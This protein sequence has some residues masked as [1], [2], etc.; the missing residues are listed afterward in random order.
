MSR[1]PALYASE[2]GQSR[3]AR[4]EGPSSTP[5]LSQSGTPRIPLQAACTSAVD[6]T[7][8]SSYIRDFDGSP[9]L[10]SRSE[11]SPD[12]GRQYGANDSTMGFAKII[13]GEDDDS[14]SPASGTIP[15]DPGRAT[16]DPQTPHHISTPLPCQGFLPIAVDAYFDRVNWY[17]MLFHQ[18]SFVNRAQEILSRSTWPQEDL[19]EVLLIIMVA[20]LGLRCVEHD[21]TWNGH[22]LLHAY[23]ATAASLSSELMMLI[24]SH[25]YEVLMEARIEAY[26]ICMLMANYHVYF[27]SS[28]FAWNV[29]GV[30]ARTAYALAL[31]CDKAKSTGGDI[32]REV[33]NRCWNHLVVSDQFSSM[34][35]G[36][37]ATLDPAFAQFKKLTDLDDTELPA[38]TARLGILQGS[39]PKV[40]FLTYHALKFEIYHIIRHTLESFKVLQLR[41]PVTVQDLKTLI[42]VVNSTEVMLEQ[43]HE[44]LPTVFKPSQW[45]ADDPWN[46]LELDR[47][48]WDE[49]NIRRKLGLQGFILQLLYDAARV[50]A[51]RP[52]LKLRISIPP[53][54]S[55]E[56][57]AI[58][59][60]PDSLGAS[61]QAALR[62]SRVPVAE[63]DG[64]LAQSFVLMHLFTAGSVLCIA[65]TCQPYSKTAG[66]AKAGVLRIISACR[67]IKDESKIAR[68]ID[69]M[70]TRLYKKT[71][72]REMDNA[73]RLPPD[74]VP[75]KHHI[76]IDHIPPVGTKHARDTA[77]TTTHSQARPHSEQLNPLVPKAMAQAAMETSGNIVPDH[78]SGSLNVQTEYHAH[79]PDGGQLPP[80]GEPV[81]SYLHF[82][83][84]RNND[85]IE[86][87]VDEDFDGTFGAFEE[88]KCVSRI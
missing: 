45:P 78:R 74:T 12:E 19:C 29:S 54:E 31:H 48:D 7:Q 38:D 28:N 4:L 42:Q 66:E 51:R 77:T 56:N 86:A 41:S 65:P 8:S 84:L 10:V 13:L 60:V 46:V 21:K 6:Q 22:Q 83:S 11:A 88:S 85:R 36:R 87:H 18:P 61:V 62:M 49:R 17:I 47:C 44:N 3:G 32:A 69:Q 33:S 16:V 72:E 55:I 71:M 37:P 34:I 64:H 35:F 26:Q 70:L 15:G 27:G 20:V 30:S 58:S 14:D 67:A 50:W 23:S 59:D 43:W 25:F 68:H 39:H 5:L 24:S 73:L 63:F 57:I 76:I 75:P 40:T 1:N 80:P 52:L 53:E 79:N 81:V 2:Q 82:E 9:D